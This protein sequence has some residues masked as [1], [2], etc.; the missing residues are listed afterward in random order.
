MQP[1]TLCFR[2]HPTSCCSA[3]LLPLV[4]SPVLSCGCLAWW[5]TW[6]HY[7]SCL[8][9]VNAD[10]C[11][12]L[13]KVSKDERAPG[14]PLPAPPYWRDKRV[15]GPS[16]SL[17]FLDPLI[18]VEFLNFQGPVCV[19]HLRIKGVTTWILSFAHMT[20]L[21]GIQSPLP[22]GC[23]EGGDRTEGWGKFVECS[24]H[25]FKAVSDS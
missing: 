25:Y 23:S 10:S 11:L 18:W 12:A 13:D 5:Q 6:R 1:R 16:P 9:L 17:V 2:K 15:N 4:L 7:Q 21:W 24:L 19:C 20:H 22:S 3:R 14:R 8:C